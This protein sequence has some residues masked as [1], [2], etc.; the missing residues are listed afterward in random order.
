MEWVSVETTDFL[1]GLRKC[2]YDCKTNTKGL[3][4]AWE[5]PGDTED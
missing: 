4:W 1:E 3:F 2:H 5:C